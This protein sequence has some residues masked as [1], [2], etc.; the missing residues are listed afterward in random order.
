MSLEMYVLSSRQLRSF[1]EWQKAANDLGLPIKI[2]S[3]VNFREVRGFLPVVW[4]GRSTGFECDH[5]T[6]EDIQET[7]KEIHIDS[8]FKH[9]MAFRWG[10]DFDALVSALQAAAAYAVATDGLVLDCQDG[11]LLTAAR[12][13]E[14]ARE[15]EAVL[16][17]L[18]AAMQ[19]ALND[20][21]SKK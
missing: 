10:A 4:Q 1:D 16:P 15:T 21:G 20:F 2:T 14:I 19:K 9:A 11:K 7:Y 3:T 6:I 18:E 8:V 12:A 13:V 17:Q 5:W